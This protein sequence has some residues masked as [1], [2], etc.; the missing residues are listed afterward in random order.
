ME[1]WICS[2]FQL[3]GEGVSYTHTSQDPIKMIVQAILSIG[4]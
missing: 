4:F 3:E 2:K 1:I